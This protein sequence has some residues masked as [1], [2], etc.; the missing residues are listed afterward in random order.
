MALAGIIAPGLWIGGHGLNGTLGAKPLEVALHE[1]GLWAVRLLLVTLAITPLRLITGWGKLMQLRRMLGVAAL[2]YTL[3]HL[4]LYV[5]QQRYDLVVVVLEII[6]RFYLTIGFVALAA[7]V[8]LGV[9]STDGSIRRMGAESWNRLHRLIYPLTVL[10]IFHAFLQAKINVSEEVVQIGVFVVL[11]AVR[12]LHRGRRLNVWSLLAL[13]LLAVPLTAG[14]E[15]L[16]YGLATGVPW[17]RIL[18]ANLM[19]ALAPRPAVVVGL[20]ALVLPLLAIFRARP[21]A[22][23]TRRATA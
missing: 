21:S 8:A 3:I 10:A 9:T 18:D 5:V 15:A 13:A 6:K 4:F 1:T 11:M 2:A 23:G 14:L 17:R 12:F 20:L 22:A 19:P 7:M 16:W